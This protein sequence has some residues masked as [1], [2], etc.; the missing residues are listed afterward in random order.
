MTSAY[1][2]ILIVLLSVSRYFCPTSAQASGFVIGGFPIMKVCQ[3]SS[4]PSSLMESVWCSSGLKI[5]I[6]N[7]A[8]ASSRGQFSVDTTSTPNYATYDT[9]NGTFHIPT[10]VQS[11][12]DFTQSST[13][14]TSYVKNKPGVY[15]KNGTL[16]NVAFKILSDTFSVSSAN[17]FAIDISPLGFTQIFSISA[18]P[19]KS[20]SSGYACPQVHVNNYTTSTVY[21]DFAQGN[22]AIPVLAVI[23][24]GTIYVTDFSGLKVNLTV[25]G[26]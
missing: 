20:V 13:S 9:S 25:I 7:K 15:S 3:D 16:R 26:Y 4:S 18:T 1:F 5:Y 14:A 24:P 21:L 11:Q 23:F 2:R 8:S 6:D 17:N 12:S 19:I 22:N 10:Y